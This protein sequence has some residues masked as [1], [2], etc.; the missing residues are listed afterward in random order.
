MKISIE[1]GGEIVIEID[2][3]TQTL[4]TALPVSGEL[5]EILVESGD[6]PIVRLSLPFGQVGALEV[7]VK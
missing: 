2:L 5:G 1:A 4:T 3:E 6:P 7:K